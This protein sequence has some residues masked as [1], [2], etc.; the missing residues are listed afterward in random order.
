[1]AISHYGVSICLF[2]KLKHK[3]ARR[4]RITNRDA[5]WCDKYFYLYY[6]LLDCIFSVLID[7]TKICFFRTDDV[8]HVINVSVQ[9]ITFFWLHF[10]CDH[11][12]LIITQVIHKIILLFF[13]FEFAQESKKFQ[14]MDKIDVQNRDRRKTFGKIRRALG[15][16]RNF[17][18]TQYITRHMV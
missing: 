17:F 7:K 3:Y 18:G 5:L 13:R 9:K 2:Y 16:L 14:K 10:C 1:M 11:Y 15:N 4:I 8:S 12:A 6:F